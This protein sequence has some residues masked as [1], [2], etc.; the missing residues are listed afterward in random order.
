MLLICDFSYVL[1]FPRHHET[2]TSLTVL[3]ESDPQKTATSFSQLFY[4]NEELLQEISLLLALSAI[5]KAAI[6]TA[7]RTVFAPFA[8]E[9][10]QAIFSDVFTPEMLGIRKNDPRAYAEL[11]SRLQCR[12]NEIVYI[13]D[14]QKNTTAAI[15]AGCLAHTFIDTKTA[16]AFL[17]QQLLTPTA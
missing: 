1:L 5:S 9:K 17:R 12:I 13:D 6:F 3:Y 7:G 4:F 2:G 16:I 15:E 14:S 8:A 10:M 11:S